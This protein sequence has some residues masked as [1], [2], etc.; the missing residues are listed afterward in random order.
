MAIREVVAVAGLAAAISGGLASTAQAAVDIATIGVSLDVPFVN[1][2]FQGTPI[3]RLVGQSVFFSQRT[4]SG[5]TGGQLDGVTT[6]DSQNA[7]HQITF[8]EVFPETNLT[9]YLTF[10]YFGVVETVD[11]VDDTETVVD[12]SIVVAANS[13]AAG[14]T[15][16]D[17]FPGLTEDVLLTALTTSFDSPEFFQA[18][19]IAT[20]S[21]NLKGTTGL[22]EIGIGEVRTG[23]SMSLYG[24]FTSEAVNG[25]F[26]VDIGFIDHSIYR[27]PTPASAGALALAGLAGLRRRR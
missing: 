5:T 21:A 13:L 9:D 24:F 10:G 16:Q 4:N 12:R 11:I 6:L 20:N 26:A 22:L 2:P 15:L 14:T 23:S 19:G 18:L 8:G 7:V 17:V 27:V 3:Y 25:D 1:G